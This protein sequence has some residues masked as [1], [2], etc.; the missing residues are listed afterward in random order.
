M[1]S[2]IRAGIGGEV[3]PPQATTGVR[4]TDRRCDKSARL[5]AV[6]PATAR[7]PPL[8]LVDAAGYLSVNVRYVRRLVAE[9]RVRYL[10]VGRLLRFRTEDLDAYLESCG[11]E[12]R[13][14]SLRS[15]RG[16]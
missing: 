3:V 2:L 1:T 14:S 15:N 12:P 10:K 8:D 13:T 11:V 7:R 4:E 16:G 9:R 5:Q 6:Q